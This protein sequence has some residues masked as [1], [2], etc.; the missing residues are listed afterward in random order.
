MINENQPTPPEE[1]LMIDILFQLNRANQIQK[2][3]LKSLDDL[4]Q[5]EAEQED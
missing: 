1:K 2:D 3:F 4:F 5:M